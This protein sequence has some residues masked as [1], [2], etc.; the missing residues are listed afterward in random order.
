MNE[1]QKLR[2]T[3]G[4]SVIAMSKKLQVHRNTITNWEALTRLPRLTQLAVERV[5]ELEGYTPSGELPKRAGDDPRSLAGHFGHT[6][7]ALG[8]RS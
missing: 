8:S 6:R 2:A 7:M 4:L 3:L 1:M 5:F